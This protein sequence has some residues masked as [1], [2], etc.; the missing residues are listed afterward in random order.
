MN[1]V[2]QM[3]GGRVVNAV[4]DNIL[5]G[6]DRH[7][8]REERIKRDLDILE[9]LERQVPATQ[10]T[11]PSATA[12]KAGRASPRV[13]TAGTEE[14]VAWQRRELAKELYRLQM[15]LA[16]G[17]MIAG[18]PCDCLSGK[19]ALGLEALAE[20]TAAMHQDPI[21]QEIIEWSRDLATK[22]T[23][24]AIASGKYR[25]DYQRMAQEARGFRK[26]LLGTE[27]VR[28]ALSDEEKQE[29][30][31]RARAKLDALLKEKLGAEDAAE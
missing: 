5:R 21:Y 29:V 20:E 7:A 9:A 25:D 4:L 26:R 27:D 3:I 2:L 18:K 6:P 14:T 8:E 12:A 24:E 17:G 22:G 11:A 15:N 30:L 19:H 13:E 31:K 1:P 16:A 23:P 28:A 10:R